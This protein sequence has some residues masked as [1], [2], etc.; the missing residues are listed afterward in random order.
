MALY[1]PNVALFLE[2]V[3]ALNPLHT[4]D[5]LRYQGLENAYYNLLVQS[6]GLPDDVVKTGLFTLSNLTWENKEE[7]MKKFGT[8]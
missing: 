2:S 1:T 7:N 4:I 8:I 5:R 6:A 3:S